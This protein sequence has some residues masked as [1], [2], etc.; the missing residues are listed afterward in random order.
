M[1]LI[2]CPKCGKEFSSFAKACPK[3]GYVNSPNTKE[4]FSEEKVSK[5]KES[6]WGKTW[7]CIALLIFLWP[8]GLFFIWKY[9]KFH[10]TARIIISAMIAI[11]VFSN[12]FGKISEEKTKEVPKEEKLENEVE[13]Q[14]PKTEPSSE[15]KNEENNEEKKEVSQESIVEDA[16][17]EAEYEKDSINL[18]DKY[19]DNFKLACSSCGI[20][21]DNVSDFEQVD[22][23]ANGER[24]GFL[25]N[26]AWYLLYLIDNGEVASI[27]DMSQN[28]I[29]KKSTPKKE[30]KSKK[31]EKEKIFLTDGDLGEYGKVDDFSGYK[32]IR[33]YIPAGRYIAECQT[34]GSGFYIET[35]EKHLESGYET[36]D[37]TAEI[38]FSNVDEKY[39]IEIKDGECISLIINSIIE[40]EKIQ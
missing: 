38:K 21:I 25:Y 16:K 11:I 6:I 28:K 15:M 24:Y 34:R 23:W 32:V 31:K 20:D 40:L 29:Y 5:E 30:K 22:D 14:E 8:V 37:T 17:E 7:V 33:Y 18:P 36:S 2:K 9:K 26:G 3:C 27:N 13:E 39:E 1:A 35:I 12:S 4:K 10:K 19:I